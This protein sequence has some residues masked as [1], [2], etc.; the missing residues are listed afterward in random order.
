MQEKKSSKKK[1]SGKLSCKKNFSLVLAKISSIKIEKN[2]R[3]SF[4][5]K[6]RKKLSSDI[7]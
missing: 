2:F 7:L 6:I 4:C 3:A 1:I 5:K